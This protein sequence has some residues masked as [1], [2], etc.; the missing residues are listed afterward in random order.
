M[1]VCEHKVLKEANDMK[2]GSELS[3]ES[4]M[5]MEKQC[6]NLCTR[7]S[8]RVFNLLQDLSQ[9]PDADAEQFSN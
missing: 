1:R 7:K 4:L 8:F 3:K 5:G 6:A 2:T 9:T